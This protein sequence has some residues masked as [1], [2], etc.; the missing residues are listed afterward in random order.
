MFLTLHFYSVLNALNFLRCLEKIKQPRFDFNK[1]LQSVTGKKNVAN[2][3]EANVRGV[4]LAA[5]VN[6]CD[7]YKA[8]DADCIM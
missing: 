3:L 8:L 1:C 4:G 5:N 6:Y 7:I 2:N